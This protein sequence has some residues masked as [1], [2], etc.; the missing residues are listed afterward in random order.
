VLTAQVPGDGAAEW[1]ENL[2]DERDVK[3]F[4]TGTDE[5]IKERRLI[6]VNGEQWPRTIENTCKRSVEQFIK[7]EPPRENQNEVYQ[8]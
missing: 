6:D 8:M 4:P 1:R 5:V 3:L 2:A 7:D